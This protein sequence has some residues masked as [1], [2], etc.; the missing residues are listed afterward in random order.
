MTACC[1]C[2]ALNPADHDHWWSG[3]QLYGT[4]PERNKELRT[5]KGGKMLLNPDGTY[6]ALDAAGVWVDSVVG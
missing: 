4:T 5:G 1:C 3:A 6:L 2:V